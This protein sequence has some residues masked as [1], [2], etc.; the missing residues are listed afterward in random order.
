MP[1][2]IPFIAK[3]AATKIFGSVTIGAVVQAVAV[4]AITSIISKALAP[5]VTREASPLEMTRDPAPI[6]GIVYG[7][8]RVSGPVT[9]AYSETVNEPNDQIWVTIPVCACEIDGFED[10]IYLADESLPLDTGSSEPDVANDYYGWVSMYRNLGTASQASNPTMLLSIPTEWTANHR[11][12][13]IAYAGVRLSHPEDPEPLFPGGFPNLS[14]IIRGRKI[15]DPRDEGQDP[16]DES[17][18]VWSDNPA[19][20]ILDYLTNDV[21]GIGAS[22]ADEIDLDTFIAAADI[23]DEEVDL[24]VGGTEKRYTCGG[25]FDTSAEPQDILN[26][27]KAT[28]AGGLYNIG[29]V[30]VLYAGAARTPETATLTTDEAR[31]GLNIQD[32]DAL[33]DTCNRV[34][35]M[36]T[37]PQDHY[38]PRPLVPQTDATYVTEDDGEDLVRDLDLLWVQSPYQAQRLAKIELERARLDK[39]VSFPGKLTA[40]QYQAGDW[41]PF[42]FVPKAWVDKSFLLTTWRLTSDPGGEGGEAPR[43]SVDLTLR[44]IDDTIYDWDETTDE[45]E[46]EPSPSTTELIEF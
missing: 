7:R 38:N 20:C 29:G 44:E 35:G 1:Q 25:R 34:T 15:Y 12:R 30:W 6:G 3:V 23:C 22:L 36:F 11:M 33:S 37:Y 9:F 5:G 19:L 24:N 42:T 8:A 16:D 45:T 43:P 10:V 40:M 32:G 26:A 46:V 18:W 41:V 27:I 14:F 2:A 13:G 21:F 17:T 28:M 4:S 31:A 39:T